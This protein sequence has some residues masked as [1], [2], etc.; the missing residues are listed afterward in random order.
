MTNRTQVDW[1]DVEDPEATMMQEL[2]A[3]N[4]NNLPVGRGSLDDFI[5]MVSV[6]EIF[7]KY[8]ENIR[9]QNRRLCP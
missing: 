7:Q 1:L 2:V 6:S 5:G 3:F 9:H 4:H 8:Y